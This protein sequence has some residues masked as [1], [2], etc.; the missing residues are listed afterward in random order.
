MWPWRLITTPAGETFRVLRKL[1]HNLLSTQQS[2]LFKKY[3]DHES[4]VLL[5]DLLDRPENVLQETER[6]AMSE[7]FSATYGIRLADLNHSIMKEF[8]DIW[9]SMLH[10]RRIRTSWGSSGTDQ[11]QT[12]SPVPCW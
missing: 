8:Y 2:C 11:G 12:F 10:C 7:I 5:C 3:Q 9:D 1:Y 4:N 6:F